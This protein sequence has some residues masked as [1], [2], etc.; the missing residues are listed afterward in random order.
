M[1]VCC[2]LFSGCTK[3]Y[4]KSSHLKAH[5]RIHTGEKPYLCHW[6]ECQWRFARSDE[7]TR[8]YRKHTGAKPF[9]CKVC[10]RS[11]ARSDHLALHMKRH[12]PKMK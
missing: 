2:F 7:L 4:T 6:P 1:W 11:F 5:Q 3:V 10:D 8:H 9:K 12:Q